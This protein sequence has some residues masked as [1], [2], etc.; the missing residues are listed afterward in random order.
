LIRLCRQCEFFFGTLTA[1]SL[2]LD[3][4]NRRLERSQFVGNFGSCW[5]RASRSQLAR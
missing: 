5:L 2:G 3:T 1:R 4:P